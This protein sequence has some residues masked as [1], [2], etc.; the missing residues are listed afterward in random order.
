VGLEKLLQVNQSRL[1]AKTSLEASLAALESEP[2]QLETVQ[3]LVALAI[4]AWRIQ[5]PPDWEAAQRFAQSAVDMA[6]QLDEA[7]VLSQALGA[8]ATVLDG[9]SL[10]REHLQV[11]Q[12]RLAIC[13]MPGFDNPAESMEATRSAGA[14]WMYVG[15]YEQAIPCLQE[16]E[17]LAVQTR[18]IEQQANA[19]G[20]QAQCL[21]R[22]DRWDEVLSLEE[23]WRGLERR[24]TRERV[25]AT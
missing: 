11:A 7:V 8:L 3:V 15:E 24:Y 14:A 4:D 25:G 23:K 9:R 16:T 22:L 20:L 5:E 10:L 13:H 2:P 17:S 21:F 19:I 18:H 1:K 12:Q 6:N